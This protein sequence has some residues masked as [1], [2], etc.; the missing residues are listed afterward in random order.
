MAK[1]LAQ[2]ENPI[3]PRLWGTLTGMT[4]GGLGSIISTLVGAVL[5]FGLLL[6]L[7]YMIWGAIDWL[8]CGGEKDKL[9][10]ARNKIVNAIGGLVALAAVWAI[11]QLVITFLGLNPLSVP[12]PET[13]VSP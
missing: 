8:T 2:I 3:I 13:R 10:R 4:E 1:L 6:T 9:D 5:V 12:T 7:L 11:W